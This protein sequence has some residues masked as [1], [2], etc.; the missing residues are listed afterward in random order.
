M[1]SRCGIGA[2]RRSI[3]T[4]RATASTAIRTTQDWYDDGN[5][6]YVS[7]LMESPDGHW[8]DLG[9]LEQLT[10]DWDDI[11]PADDWEDADAEVQ[12]ALWDP[13]PGEWDIYGDHE[14]VVLTEQEGWMF[15]DLGG[16]LAYSLA[17]NPSPFPTGEITRANVGGDAYGEDFNVYLVPLSSS[18]AG[19]DD[20]QPL[21]YDD[22]CYD[23][24][25]HFGHP[26][27]PK[28]G[29]SWMTGNSYFL[30]GHSVS[31]FWEDWYQPLIAQGK[32]AACGIT[33]SIWDSFN[34]AQYHPWAGFVLMSGTSTT[35]TRDGVS[36]P[37]PY[38]WPI[39]AP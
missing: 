7:A 38:P 35:F 36:P 29:G 12:Y 14:Y 30:D 37:A 2:G 26:L 8:L 24:D 31:L 10:R 27:Q 32:L 25:G 39:P 6:V 3:G 20:E 21:S 13:G 11:T 1:E 28:T 23:Q 16:D 22:S 34:G 19:L 18:W 5:T 17:A 9:G 15:N 33:V 4:Q